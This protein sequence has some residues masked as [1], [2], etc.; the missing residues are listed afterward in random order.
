IRACLALPT[1]ADGA[2]TLKVARV[3][4]A[5][6]GLV[7]AWTAHAAS[8]CELYQQWYRWRGYHKIWVELMA[9]T[10][11][12]RAPAMQRRRALPAGA[13][14]FVPPDATPRGSLRRTP[15]RRACLLGC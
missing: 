10:S 9:P 3:D 7:A 4:D 14:N 15:A 5:S 13:S 12:A 8:S 2:A 1:T 6:S 11:T